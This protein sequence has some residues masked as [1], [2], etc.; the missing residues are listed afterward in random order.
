MIVTSKALLSSTTAHP[1]RCNGT[2]PETP[3]AILWIFFCRMGTGLCVTTELKERS[4]ELCGPW[5]LSQSS[6]TFVQ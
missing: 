6:V 1:L 2:A 5:N 4:D 3:Q